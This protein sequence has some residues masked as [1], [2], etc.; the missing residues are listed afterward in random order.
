MISH[1]EPGGQL[2]FVDIGGWDARI[3]PSHILTVVTDSGERISGVVGTPPPH[4]LDAK[5]RERPARLDELFVD[6]GV[7]SADEAQALGIRVGRLPH[8]LRISRPEQARRG[9]QGAD[10]RAGCAAIIKALD[11]LR[12]TAEREPGSGLFSCSKRSACSAQQRQPSDNPT[13]PG[14]GTGRHDLRRRARRAA[15]AQRHPFRS[16]PAITVADGIAGSCRV[17]WCAR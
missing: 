5:D 6:I 13:R 11:G 17:E 9:R 1:I 10:D 12:G 16:R 3:I 15:G 4:I 2:R 7:N 14:T 8:R